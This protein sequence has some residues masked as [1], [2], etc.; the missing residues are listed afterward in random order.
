MPDLVGIVGNVTIKY[1]PDTVEGVVVKVTPEVTFKVEQRDKQSPHE[2]A[3]ELG[4]LVGKK[5]IIT[6]LPEQPELPK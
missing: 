4:P 3:D 5:C 1:V 6:I 2:L